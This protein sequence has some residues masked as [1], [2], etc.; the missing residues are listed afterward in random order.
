MQSWWEKSPP[1]D[2]SM[3]IYVTPSQEMSGQDLVTIFMS[4]YDAIYTER[5]FLLN[6]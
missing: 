3:E 5:R 1:R 4:P 6:D 2:L